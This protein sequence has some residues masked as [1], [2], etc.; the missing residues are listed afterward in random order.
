[1]NGESLA[2]QMF[3]HIMSAEKE[4]AIKLAN[5]MLDRINADPDDDLAVLSRQF[6]RAL[7]RLGEYNPRLG[8]EFD[9]RALQ[10]LRK[11]SK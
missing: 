9:W 5:K 11:A 2:D 3:S 7:E 6:L 1:M 10:A 8:P 4:L